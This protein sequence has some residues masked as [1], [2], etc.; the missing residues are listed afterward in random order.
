MKARYLK[1]HVFVCP[2]SLEN[3]PNSVGEAMLLGVPVVC[4]NVGG[5][6]SLLE[7]G[8]EGILYELGNKK[9]LI[10]A[11]SFVFSHDEKAQSFSVKERARGRKNHDGAK[12]FQALMQIYEQMGES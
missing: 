5:I 9:A 1:S 3:S 10:D 2:S 12:N 7:D 11:I 4:S 8:K 6:P